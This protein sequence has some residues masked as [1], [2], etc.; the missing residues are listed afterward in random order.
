MF[1]VPISV[2]NARPTLLSAAHAHFIARARTATRQQEHPGA[3]RLAELWKFFNN[4]ILPVDGRMA[5]PMGPGLG[6]EP[7]EAA[8]RA[9]VG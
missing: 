6:L 3:K 7:N 1:D 4:R 2:H 5:V 8:I 9:A